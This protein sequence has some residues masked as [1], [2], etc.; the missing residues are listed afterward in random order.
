MAKIFKIIPGLNRKNDS[1][2]LYSI[3]VHIKIGS[4]DT[5]CPISDEL[6]PDG[7]E[8]E[9]K[10]ITEELNELL[11]QVKKTG[12]D[13]GAFFIDENSPPD[14]IWTILSTVSD[15][16]MFADC[17]NGLEEEKRREVAA[18]ILENCNIFTGKGAYFSTHYV[19]ETGLME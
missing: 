9:L 8:S 3:G 1:A 14:E 6:S 15:N 19:Q 7:L 4:H 12:N 18:Y 2:T 5:V 11:K 16:D 10:S 17:F 13:E